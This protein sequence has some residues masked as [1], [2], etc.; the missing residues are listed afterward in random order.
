MGRLHLAELSRQR[1]T[2]LSP[3]LD[4]GVLSCGAL[5]AACADAVV[6][7]AFTGRPTPPLSAGAEEFHR[8]CGFGPDPVGQREDEDDLALRMVGATGVRLGIPEA[9]Y[10]RDESGAYRYAHDRDLSVAGLGAESALIAEL[11]VR[12]ADEPR[13]RD[14][15]L[16]LA[17]LAVGGHIDHRITAAAAERLGRA[18]GT[19]LWYEDVPY[20]LFPPSMRGPATRTRRGARVCRFR[21][22]HWRTKLAAIE[23]YASQRDILWRNPTGLAKMMTFRARLLGWGAPAERCWSESGQA[24]D[25]LPAA[26]L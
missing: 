14:A 13:V 26:R 16:V 24:T 5:L 9:L 6:V 12:L 21:A 3:H 15:D 8:R 4:D 2:V 20:V 17:P 11:A 25:T 23:C 18:P 10:R 1:V 19:L 7:T 22:E